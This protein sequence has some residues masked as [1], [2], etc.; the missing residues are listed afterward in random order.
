MAQW[1][2]AKLLQPIR[3]TKSLASNDTRSRDH[4]NFPS[5]G[6]RKSASEVGDRLG[7]LHRSGTIHPSH[8]GRTREHFH[9]KSSTKARRISVWGQRRRVSAAT[10]CR[11][12]A[13]RRFDECSHSC[14]FKLIDHDQSGP[15]ER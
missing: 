9:G 8:K 4:R 10:P 5:H 7:V 13:T 2:I 12:S 14:K 11:S 1:R 15:C 6:A 3:K